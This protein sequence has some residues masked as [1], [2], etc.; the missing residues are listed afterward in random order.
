MRS[1]VIAFPVTLAL[2]SAS[3]LR[4]QEITWKETDPKREQF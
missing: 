1:R 2:L 4:A 3:P